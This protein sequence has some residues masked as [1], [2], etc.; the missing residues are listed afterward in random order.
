MKQG[1]K[2]AR[3]TSCIRMC[4]QESLELRL[5]HRHKGW[6]TRHR[7]AGPGK[8]LS[9][10]QS[11]G[12]SS[13]TRHSTNETPGAL[14]TPGANTLR[15]ADTAHPKWCRVW[16][17]VTL[18]KRHQGESQSGVWNQ[19]THSTVTTMHRTDKH[20]GLPCDT[21]NLQSTSCNNL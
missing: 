1:K 8:T 6:G 2:L 19:Q 9:K 14:H 13:E 17:L 15:A 10:Y 7:P 11:D 12:L 3:Q 4:G 16:M 5:C 20:H 18:Y 21:V